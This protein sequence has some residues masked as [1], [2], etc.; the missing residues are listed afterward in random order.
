MSSKKNQRDTSNN[1]SDSPAGAIERADNQQTTNPPSPRGVG[2]SI[3]A[4]YSGPIL[5][6]QIE[7]YERSELGAAYMRALIKQT[8]H[9]MELEQLAVR[10]D[11]MRANRGQKL[12]FSVA[13]IFCLTGSG[14]VYTGH[15]IAGATIAT[16]A[17]VGLV[18]AFVTGT[19]QRKAERVEKTKIM[20]EIRTDSSRRSRE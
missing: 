4:S 10:G 16:A 17:V 19:V 11:N 12:A 14:L 3:Q 1:Q 6:Q 20:A 8:E 13:M 5:P 18:S 7:A 15:D 2:S 9:R